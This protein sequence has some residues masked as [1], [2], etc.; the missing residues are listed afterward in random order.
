M[1]NYIIN[2]PLLYLLTKKKD[3]KKVKPLNE[4]NAY[5]GYYPFNLEISKPKNPKVNVS[6]GL[7]K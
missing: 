7:L 2:S 6:L 5:S 4:S 3:C 1:K